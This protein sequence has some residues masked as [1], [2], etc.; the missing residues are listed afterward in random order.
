MNPRIPPT[1]LA[2]LVAA[3]SCQ[4]AQPPATASPTPSETAP[5]MP[6]AT[7]VPSRPAPT[8]TVSLVTPPPSEITLTMQS[9]PSPDGLWSAESSF[10]QLEGDAGFRVR[11]VVRKLDGTAEWVPVDYTQDGLGY[12][13]PALRYWSPDSRTVAYFN[14]PTPDGCG[15]FYPEEDQWAVLDVL[16]GSL[17]NLPLPPG[18]GHTIS[19]DGGTMIFATNIPPY[20]LRFRDTQSGEEGFL[21]FPPAAEDSLEIQ[22]GGWVWSPDGASAALSIAYGDSCGDP[23][24]LSFSVVRIDDLMTPSVVPLIEGPNLVRLERWEAPHHILA[25]D[26]GG[27]SWWMDSRTGET[28]PAP[29]P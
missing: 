26:W 16:D 8:R 7:K 4:T 1:F 9:L 2:L 3:A 15:D 12:V 14:M 5:D 27:Y 29:T 20:G 23:G 13:Y 17:S 21:P 18:R 6:P 11:L 19:P 22:A 25:R 24:S 10:E 28:V